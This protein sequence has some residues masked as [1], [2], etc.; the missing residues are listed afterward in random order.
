MRQVKVFLNATLYDWVEKNAKEEEL[1][2]SEFIRLKLTEA[3]MKHTLAQELLKIKRKQF[4]KMS[5]AKTK[6]E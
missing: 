4:Q 3:R 5:V 2:I 6:A 1:S